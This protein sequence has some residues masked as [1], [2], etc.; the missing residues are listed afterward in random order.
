MV[1]EIW[2][3][4]EA[5]SSHAGVRF[6][7]L[8]AD[9]FF[10]D[11]ERIELWFDSLGHLVH[12]DGA[13]GEVWDRDEAESGAGVIVTCGR[14]GDICSSSSESCSS[15]AL[16]QGSSSSYCFARKNEIQKYRL[17]FDSLGHLTRVDVCNSIRWDVDGSTSS[18]PDDLSLYAGIKLYVYS[19]DTESSSCSS[20]SC[21]TAG[22]TDN[23][24][25]PKVSL[26]PRVLH[27]DS[28]GHLVHVESEPPE[29]WACGWMTN[30]CNEPNVGTPN[31]LLL[32]AT[33]VTRELCIVLNW[34]R[35]CSAYVGTGEMECPPGPT[36]VNNIIFQCRAVTSN[37]CRWYLFVNGTATSTGFNVS[38]C[39]PFLWSHNVV[40]G[41][42]GCDAECNPQTVAG[43]EITQVPCSWTC[44]D[45][46]ECAAS[47]SSTGPV[48]S[49]PIE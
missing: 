5:S 20:S 29:D 45:G 42:N 10:C 17:H 1:V 38:Q 44:N 19:M 26:I 16:E 31:R 25:C 9:Q 12:V 30:C 33:F 2:D 18:T 43:V 15:E 22:S 27:F 24:L 28:I 7:V 37:T 8:P 21:S 35:A 39:C 11:C 4:N 32:I 14:I 40:G 3:V 47:G 6:N 13:H 49:G 36:L 23:T 48:S 41:W 46:Y 34:D